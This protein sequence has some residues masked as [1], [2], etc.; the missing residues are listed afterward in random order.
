MDQL[1]MPRLHEH[2]EKG[3]PKLEINLAVR[4]IMAVMRTAYAKK[5]DSVGRCF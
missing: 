1:R 5:W 3:K 2:L 4:K